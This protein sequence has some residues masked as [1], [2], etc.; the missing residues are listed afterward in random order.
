MDIQDAL[1]KLTEGQNHKWEKGKKSKIALIFEDG[2]GK[3]FTIE[4][5]NKNL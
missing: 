2:V 3:Y 5:K 4:M 1:L